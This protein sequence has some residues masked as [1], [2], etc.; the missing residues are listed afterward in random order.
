MAKVQS[1]LNSH[2]NLEKALHLLQ[3]LL[4]PGVHDELFELAAE[5]E[6]A[7]ETN[8][9]ERLYQHALD[10]GYEAAL[11]R[12]ASLLEGR[13]GTQLERYGLE[14]DGT[15]SEAWAWPARHTDD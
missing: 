12:L 3:E 13:P 9:A 15:P 6:R 8:E 7:G 4:K 10:L 5:R 2:T 14:A 1:R 11:P